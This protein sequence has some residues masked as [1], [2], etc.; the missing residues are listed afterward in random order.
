MSKI[1]HGFK[2]AFTSII[3]GFILALILKY[4]FNYYELAEFIAI[5]YLLSFF[6]VYLIYKKMKY[7]SIWYSLG[8]MIG[9]LLFYQLLENWEFIFYILVFIIAI[10]YNVRY[11]IKRFLRI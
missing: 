1:Y 8:W 3:I 10:G 7:W 9:I 11:K 2:R 5:F 4:L 6:G